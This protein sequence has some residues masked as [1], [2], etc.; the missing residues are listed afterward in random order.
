MLMLPVP[1]T[2]VR[3]GW[4]WLIV[5]CTIGAAVFAALAIYYAARAI[6][7]ADRKAR[8]AQD[9]VVRERRNVFELGV[10]I[11]LIEVCSTVERGAA[12]IARALLEVLPEQ[13]V[14][15]IRAEVTQGRVPSNEALLPFLPEYLAAV[16]RR[17]RDGETG[18]V[19]QARQRRFKAWKQRRR[20]KR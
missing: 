20:Q 8:E 15:G 5:W 4:D 1:V 14:P 2:T 9:A 12:P 16:D 6:R 7:L 13:D 17:L 11:R 10:L 3:D 19:R 18:T